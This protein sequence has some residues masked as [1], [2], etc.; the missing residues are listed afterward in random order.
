MN[1]IRVPVQK[2]SLEK[3]QKILDVGFEL[4]CE[5]GYGKTNTVEIA[6]LA[7]VSTGVVYCYFKDKRQI[8]IAAFESYLK[9]ISEQLFEKLEVQQPFQLSNFVE[10]WITIYL[11]LYAASGRNLAHLRMM[12]SEDEEINQHFAELEN[13]YFLKMVN[14]LHKNNITPQNALEKVYACC[15]LIDSLR[16]EKS[17]FSHSGIDF[18]AFYAQVSKTVINLLSS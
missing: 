5:K 12:I 14:I 16:Q 17:A 18:T 3:K 11:D 13:K 8:Y 9:N 2:R 4:F 7:G 6:K 1:D 10:S 15:I